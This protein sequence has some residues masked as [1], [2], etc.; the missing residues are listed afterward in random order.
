MVEAQSEG[1]RH[2]P[3]LA[4]GWV[5]R[6]E[7]R[8]PRVAFA[9]GDD[10]RVREAAHDLVGLGIKP[11]LVS[12]SSLGEAAAGVDVLSLAELAAGPV[13]QEV[14]DALLERGISEDVASLRRLDPT[15]LATRLTRRGDTQATVAGSARPTSDV[16]R[17]GLQAMGL[18]EG[19]STLSSSFLM[20]LPDGRNLCFADC[21]VIPE[22]TVRQL[23]DIA[24]SSAATYSA[25]TGEEPVVAL[26][27]FSTK[28][29]AKH[30]SLDRLRE[31]RELVNAESPEL[32]ID[33]ELQ[34]DA[35]F[36]ESVAARKAPGSAVAGHA[37]VF[38]FPDLASG[39][40]GYK[41]AERLGGA[42]SYGPL[43]QGLSGVLNDLSR[44]CTADDIVNVAL[45]SALQAGQ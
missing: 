21:A 40:I 36:V 32:V 19:V 22:P 41:I 35:A 26:L 6:L 7:G 12:D 28:G 16:L 24:R 45:I 37:N 2:R 8:R 15:F 13:G 18:A 11:V 34:F 1:K 29:S 38:V 20:H 27:S 23:A 10:D 33:D 3:T 4:D 25:L 43:L 5:A 39:N 14:Q 30:R 9:D 42:S 31:A 17:A 44:G